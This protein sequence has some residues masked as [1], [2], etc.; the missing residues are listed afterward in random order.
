MFSAK[1]LGKFCLLPVRTR[2]L[3]TIKNFR[4]E[5][6]QFGQGDIIIIQ[7]GGDFSR[8]LDNDLQAPMYL[9]AGI[10][11]M[12]IVVLP[13]ITKCFMSFVSFNRDDGT[14]IKELAVEKGKQNYYRPMSMDGG[15]EYILKFTRF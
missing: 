6:R 8:V 11:T 12:F 9:C 4:N 10:L 3:F 5:A 14:L 2:V 15:Y 13:P 1:C 7:R